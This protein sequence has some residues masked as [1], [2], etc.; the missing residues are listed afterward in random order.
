MRLIALVALA[1]LAGSVAAAP[2]L[3]YADVKALADKD[4]AS[5]SPQQSAEL[6]SAQSALL[7]SGTAACA[8]PN[9]DLSALV[10]VMELDAQGKVARTWLQGTSPLAICL[11]KHAAG[12]SLP[13]PPRAPFYTSIEL[14]FT[15]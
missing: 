14:S 2:T 5:L 9:P 10:V 15:K 7:E 6:R 8:T 4:E 12:Q 3:E 11:R 1:L 13:A